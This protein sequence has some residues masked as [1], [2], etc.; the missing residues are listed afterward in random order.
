MSIQTCF[1][2]FLHDCIIISITLVFWV[3]RKDIEM[4]KMFVKSIEKASKMQQSKSPLKQKNSA[5]SKDF[6]QL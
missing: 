3:I 6:G 1:C 5:L 4:F 2:A